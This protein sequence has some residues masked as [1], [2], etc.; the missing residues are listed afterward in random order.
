MKKP[1]PNRQG[2]LNYLDTIRGIERDKEKFLE[3]AHL[4][5]HESTAPKN[6]IMPFAIL[7]GIVLLCTILV[8]GYLSDSFIH[9]LIAVGVIAFF[10]IV[11]LN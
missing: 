1:N 2:F 6:N 9:A 11:A 5:R 7:G 3:A 4:Q 8:L 10:G